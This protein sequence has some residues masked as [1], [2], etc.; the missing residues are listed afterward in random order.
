MLHLSI[1]AKGTFTGS[2]WNGQTNRA[3]VGEVIAREHELPRID[4]TVPMTKAEPLKLSL[5]LHSPSDVRGTLRQGE[6]SAALNG[7]TSPWHK[8]QQPLPLPQRGTHTA[9]LI[10]QTDPLAAP[11]G[12]RV[13]ASIDG[14][15]Y[16]TVSFSDRR[17]ALCNTRLSPEGRWLL[18][19]RPYTGRAPTHGQGQLDSAAQLTASLLRLGLALIPYSTQP[20]SSD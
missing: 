9:R 2:L 4:I 18:W 5:E 10:H 14:I 3:L 6:A 19:S 20:P 15:A 1:T 11:A 7:W 17:V 8:T 12:L 13:Q 16:L